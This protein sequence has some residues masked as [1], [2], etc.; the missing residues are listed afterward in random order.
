LR[1]LLKPLLKTLLICCDLYYS[2]KQ[3]G[4]VTLEATVEE[5][6]PSSGLKNVMNATR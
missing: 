6:N 1:S 3:L 4:G 5:G 2:R